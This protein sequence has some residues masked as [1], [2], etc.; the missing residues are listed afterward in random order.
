MYAL[1]C[2][3]LGM[4]RPLTVTTPHVPPHVAHHRP[5]PLYPRHV[6]HHRRQAR[7]KTQPHVIP[8]PRN[9]RPQPNRV[10]RFKQTRLPPERCPHVPRRQHVQPFKIDKPRPP[11]A[12]QQ[13]RALQPRHAPHAHRAQTREPPQPHAPLQTPLAQSSQTIQNAAKYF[14]NAWT[15]SVQTKTQTCADARVHHVRTN[16]MT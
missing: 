10:V 7:H 8:Q 4:Q 9:A 3:P 11:P 16:S 15:N 2:L 1:A 6:P 13:P 14:T 5:P 12:A